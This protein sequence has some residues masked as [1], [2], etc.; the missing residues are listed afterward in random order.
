MVKRLVFYRTLSIFLVFLLLSI[1]VGVKFVAN[2]SSVTAISRFYPLK[3]F[4]ENSVLTLAEPDDKVKIQAYQLK[5]RVIE[6][7]SLELKLESLK[8]KGDNLELSSLQT[9]IAS[10]RSVAMETISGIRTNLQY[11]KN[12]AEVSVITDE[13]NLSIQELSQ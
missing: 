2:S 7:R 8:A 10:T 5:Q 3:L 6:L 11:V 12:P 13:L 4:A 1:L 9:A